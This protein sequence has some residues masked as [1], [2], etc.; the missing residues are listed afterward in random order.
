MSLRASSSAM[1]GPVVGWQDTGFAGASGSGHLEGEVPIGGSVGEEVVMGVIV[2]RGMMI[3]GCD[4]EESYFF[5]ANA[6]LDVLLCFFDAFDEI[7]NALPDLL[8]FGN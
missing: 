1:H 7:S 4:G 6:L 5:E 2:G 8:L 3:G